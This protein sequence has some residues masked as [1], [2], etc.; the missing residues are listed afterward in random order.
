MQQGIGSLATGITVALALVLT[1]CSA[2]AEPSTATSTSP[3]PSSSASSS[4]TPAAPE[5]STEPTTMVIGT[6]ALSLLLEDGSVAEEF[7]YADSVDTVVAALADLLGAE[8]AVTAY[9]GT[10][11][12]DYEWPGLQVGT[13]GPTDTV[14]W[15][16][17][18]I[19]ASVAEI[20]GIAIE[21]AEGHVVG[22]DLQALAAANPE[23]TRR[24]QSQT[25]E[26]L[27]VEVQQVAFE[28]TDLARAFH[29]ELVA[30]PSDGPI[31][32]IA[33]PRKNF[34]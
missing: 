17:T 23:S 29:T 6:S 7:A 32:S 28:G 21:S 22:D 13:D 26:E 11:A 27:V 19:T 14:N 12:V 15:P 31:T 18:Y 2:D 25:G 8:P 1:G 24:W 4:P 34:E 16:E 30:N 3:T 5:V 10:A 20:N 33:A 9:E